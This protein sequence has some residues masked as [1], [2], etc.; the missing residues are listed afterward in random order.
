MHTLIN[1]KKYL[2]NSV[3]TKDTEFNGKLFC[4]HNNKS[5]INIER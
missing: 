4:D 3:R 2:I 5:R 1:D